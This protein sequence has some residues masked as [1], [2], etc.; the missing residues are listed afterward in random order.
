MR[1]R[2]S[3]EAPRLRVED[4]GEQS[5]LSER[6]RFGFPMLLGNVC[7][8]KR[9]LSIAT[10]VRRGVLQMRVRGVLDHSRICEFRVVRGVRVHG[11]G[12]AVSSFGHRGSGRSQHVCI[13]WLNSMGGRNLRS[14][15]RARDFH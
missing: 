14:P 11:R 7:L 13:A 12:K 5:V 6:R 4:V 15:F 1:G 3:S 10:G 2:L 8:P 9:V